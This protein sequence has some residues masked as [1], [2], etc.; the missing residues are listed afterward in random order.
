LIEKSFKKYGISNKLNGMEDDYQWDSDPDHTSSVDDDDE[1]SRRE[2][3][4]A[5]NF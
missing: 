1:E 3:L 4:P 5:S 2:Y